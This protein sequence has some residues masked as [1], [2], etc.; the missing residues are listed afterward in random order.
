M[1]WAGFRRVR[2]QVRKRLS[3]RLRQLGLRN[4]DEY[5]VHLEAHPGEWDVLDSLCRITI[6]RFYRD[7]MV[8]D[9]LR[10]SILPDL[11][12]AARE[13]GQ[14]VIRCWSAG[15]ASGEEPYSLC[16][17]WRLGAE[18][19]EP[20]VALEITATEVDPGLLE[21]ARVACYPRGSVKELPAEWVAEAFTVEDETLCLGSRFGQPVRFMRQDIR[22]EMPPGPFDLVLCRNLVFT[23]FDTALQEVLL[24]R[25]LGRMV[26]GGFFVY[27]AHETL[28]ARDWPLERRHGALPILRLSEPPGSP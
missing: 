9:M 27:G 15:C 3:R 6:S 4:L 26:P 8:F 22:Y 10:D 19:R 11:A 25:M 13:R 2:G 24:E 23:Y 14:A 28:P 20:D 7:R 16:L 17:A 1:R 21:R 12:R 18:R 5:R